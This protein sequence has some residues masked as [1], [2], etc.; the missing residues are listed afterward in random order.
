VRAASGRPRTNSIYGWF[1]EDFGGTEADVGAHLVRHAAPPLLAEDA[2]DWR[3]NDA[4]GG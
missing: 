1:R 4:R 3:L 2:D